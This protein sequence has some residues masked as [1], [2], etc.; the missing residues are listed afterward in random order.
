MTGEQESKTFILSSEQLRLSEYTFSI[1]GLVLEI[2]ENLLQ[3]LSW[4][5]PPGF[6]GFPTNRNAGG[7]ALNC[8]TLPAS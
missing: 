3:P 8:I 7:K 6:Q 2:F 1:N 4:L 5:Q